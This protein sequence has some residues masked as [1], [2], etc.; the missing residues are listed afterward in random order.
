MSPRG[1]D[2]RR[3]TAI[4]TICL[5][6]LFGLV[7]PS[8]ASSS[9]RPFHGTV[10]GEATFPAVS[11]AVCPPSSVW[12]GGRQTVSEADGVA[13]H[14][15]NVHM[16]SAHC[17]PLTDKLVGGDMTLVAANGDQLFMDYSGT[18]PF[19]PFSAVPGV[20]VL[21]C[22]TELTVTGGT[23]RFDG[24]SGHADMVGRVL[25]EGFGDPAWAGTWTWNGWIGY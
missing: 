14:L 20:T 17:T 6:A 3:L 21:T 15:G 24:A 18:C 12:V 25:F 8:A 1:W 19:D 5:L 4:V 22:Q 10:S 7:G 11:D 9:H 2:M 16:T 13:S 23:G